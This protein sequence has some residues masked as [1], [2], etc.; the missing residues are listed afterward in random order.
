MSDWDD[1]FA[2]AAGETTE[3]NVIT[4]SNSNEII[5]PTST[6]QTNYSERN[7]KKRK[8]TKNQKIDELKR[9]EEAS[10]LVL[11]EAF[12]KSRLDPIDKQIC[13]FPSWLKLG[14]SLYAKCDSKLFCSE[15]TPPATSSYLSSSSS[16]SNNDKCTQCSMSPLYHSTTTSYCNEENVG[17]LNHLALIR[18]IR[19]CASCIFDMILCNDNDLNN[20]NND[21]NLP[22]VESKKEIFL[23]YAKS[24]KKKCKKLFNYESLINTLS[25]GERNVLHNKF[26]NVLQ[27]TENLYGII[28]KWQR[29]MNSSRD[30]KK[31]KIDETLAGGGDSTFLLSGCFDALVRVLIHADAA[32][33]RMYYLQVAGYFPVLGSDVENM[34]HLPHPPT[35]FGVK[36]LTWNVILGKQWQNEYIN[37]V[38]VMHADNNSIE[39]SSDTLNSIIN[40]LGLQQ[41]EEN[42][43]ITIVGE[44]QS[45]DP[46][47]FLYQNR[48]MEGHLIFGKSKWTESCDAYLE[49]SK[50]K[51]TSADNSPNKFASANIYRIHETLAPRVLAEWRD[52][53]RDFLCHLYSYATLHPSTLLSIQQTIKSFVNVQSLVEM[54]SGTGYLAHLVSSQGLDIDAYDITPTK[55]RSQNDSVPLDINDYH[56]STPPFFDVQRGDVNIFK[57]MHKRN[58]HFWSTTALLLC[59]PPPLVS[60]ADEILNAYSS[61]GGKVVIHVGEFSGLTGSKKF[62]I[63]LKANFELIKRFDCLH[64]GTDS[65][66][67]TIWY[68]KNRNSLSNNSLL[69]PCSGCQIHESTRQ[70]RFLRTL[71][72]CSEKCFDNHSSIRSTLFA[73]YNVPLWSSNE[74][75]K[76]ISFRN[77]EHFRDITR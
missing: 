77:R 71:R 66:D 64:W 50:L 30:E 68:A 21:Q 24:S 40:P 29:K 33:Y 59:Y 46:L 65:A 2:A 51:P 61:A 1:L 28:K 44:E 74:R 52:S 63:M 19:C 37:K 56:G 18:D 47:S 53:C 60:M 11:L 42:E 9:D 14:S 67:V 4:E 45:L 55:N 69:L 35:Y 73:F 26:Q 62:Q 10:S 54:G 22:S 15:Y 32:Y 34:I 36:N 41:V 72:Y 58:P 39:V 5:S 6:Q 20:H 7:K 31:K 76:C 8:I 17:I 23:E 16:S 49:T 48:F 75:R 43:A 3:C 27:S 25:V 57:S 12:L 38:V 13:S 70:C